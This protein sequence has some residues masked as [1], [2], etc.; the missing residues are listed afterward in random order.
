[1]RQCK[2]VYMH[3]Q[4]LVYCYHD[5]C[6]VHCLVSTNGAMA[7]SPKSTVDTEVAASDNTQATQATDHGHGTGIGSGRKTVGS[8]CTLLL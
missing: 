8:K 7:S 2:N 6:S 3:T 5:T 1:M 4:L